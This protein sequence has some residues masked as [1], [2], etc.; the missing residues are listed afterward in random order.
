MRACCGWFGA[1]FKNT[2]ESPGEKVGN[3]QNQ[4]SPIRSNLRGSSLRHSPGSFELNELRNSSVEL[5]EAKQEGSSGFDGEE[6]S[7]IS[8]SYVIGATPS[9]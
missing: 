7:S 9:Q 2:E 6:G 3:Q 4:G 1:F 8:D 5:V